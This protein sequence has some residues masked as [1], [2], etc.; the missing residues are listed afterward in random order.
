MLAG[1]SKLQPTG[2]MH[3]R[4]AVNAAQHKIVNLLKHY[5]I[6]FVIMCHNVFNVWP[7]TT[8]LLPVWPR[9][10]KMSDTPGLTNRVISK[11]GFPAPPQQSQTASASSSQGM[12]GQ[13]SYLTAY[14]LTHLHS[15]LYI[16]TSFPL[17]ALF[18]PRKVVGTK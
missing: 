8:L 5:E 12:Q 9:D 4:M 7:K 2:H 3:P 6:L 1:M 10:T 15:L 11:Q 18:I 14:T 13:Q 16:P 17:D